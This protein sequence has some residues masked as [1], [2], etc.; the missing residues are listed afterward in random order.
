MDSNKPEKE[1][2]GKKRN[3]ISYLLITFHYFNFRKTL[4]ITI[5]QIQITII[6]IKTIL[7]Q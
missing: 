3:V 2:L 5:K 7:Y 6:T 4:K 1:F